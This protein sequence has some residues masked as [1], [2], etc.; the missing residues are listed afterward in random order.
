MENLSLS[1]D[2]ETTLALS[3]VFMLGAVFKAT[4]VPRQCALRQINSVAV[5]Y[6][7]VHEFNDHDRRT[8]GQTKITQV[9]ALWDRFSSMRRKDQRLRC[10]FLCLG[11]ILG[12]MAYPSHFRKLN[13]PVLSF[14][15]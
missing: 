5:A 12:L 11:T 13:R 15:L 3:F 1:I 9:C 6:N 8:D 10:T 7:M 14:R 2:K 4:R